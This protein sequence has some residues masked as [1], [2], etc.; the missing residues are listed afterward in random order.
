[1]CS[2]CENRDI[3]IWPAINS[4]VFL[5]NKLIT[6]FLVWFK[7]SLF[8]LL[9]IEIDHINYLLTMSEDKS[10]QAS[11]NLPKPSNKY[12]VLEVT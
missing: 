4:L 6:S 8:V 11:G 1:M 7:I 12:S 2:V 9:L 10:P 3:L 5:S